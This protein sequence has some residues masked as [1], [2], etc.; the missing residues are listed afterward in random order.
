MADVNVIYLRFLTILGIG[1]FLAAAVR[2]GAHSIVSDNVKHFPNESLAPYGLE[3]L[4][5][6]Q[7]L[8]HQYHI[9]PDAFIDVLIDQARD[10]KWT[11]EQLISKHVP[12]LSTLISTKGS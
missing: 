11:L 1:A 6:D 12:S 10:V 2:C 5:A 8:E 4:T 9:D 3:C 7:F